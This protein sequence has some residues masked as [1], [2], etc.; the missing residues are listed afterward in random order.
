MIALKK[1]QGVLYEQV[2][3]WIISRKAQLPQYEEFNKEHGRMEELK[4]E[5]YI[6]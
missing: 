2:H 1:N 6:I 3:A 5:K 4:K